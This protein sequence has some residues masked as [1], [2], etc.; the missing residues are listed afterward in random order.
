MK[1]HP[2]PN[3]I[4]LKTEEVKV[5]VLDTSSKTSAIEYA[6]V[7]A[8]AEDVNGIKVGDMIFVKSW[9]IDS[10]F[11]ENKWYRFVNLETNAVL[12]V[13]K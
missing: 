3:I 7:L 10:I 12:A 2:Q 9:G 1:I 11:Y 13:I 8:I 6:E 4:Y 5:G